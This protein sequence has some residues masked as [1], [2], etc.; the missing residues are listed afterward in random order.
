M[1]LMHGDLV[2]QKKEPNKFYFVL[3]PCRPADGFTQ[4]VV[5]NVE[6]KNDFRY[7]NNF[8]F[9]AG[10]WERYTESTKEI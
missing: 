1:V 9:D 2:F 5:Q 8:W 4:V 7:I 6:D 3:N 10:S